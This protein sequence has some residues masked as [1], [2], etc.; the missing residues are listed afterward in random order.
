[1][2]AFTILTS[3]VG[4]RATICP[5]RLQRKGATAALSQSGRAIPD[6]PIRAIP[7]DVRDKRQMSSPSSLC[8]HDYDYAA[9]AID[10]SRNFWRPRFSGGCGASVEQSS[11]T[12][13]GRLEYAYHPVIRPL[14]QLDLCLAPKRRQTKVHLFQLSYN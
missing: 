5:R 7:V 6:E 1:M 2:S 13:P 14:K 4:G 9:G 3:C 12:D 10:S 11:S 8:R